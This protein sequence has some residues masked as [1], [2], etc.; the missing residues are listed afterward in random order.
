METKKCIWMEAGA[1]EYQL[2]PLKLNCDLCEF[3]QEM[4]SGSKT[5]AQLSD[6]SRFP[7]RIPDTS[8]L[9]FTA[10]VQF[11]QGHFWYKRVARGR[12]QLGIDSFLWQL[13]SSLKKVITPKL[14][15]QILAKQCFGWLL[16]EGG[17]VYLKSPIQGSILR[18]NPLFLQESIHDPHLYLVPQADLWLVEMEVDELEEHERLT[19]DGYLSM[20]ASSKAQ[21]DAL[22]EGDHSSSPTPRNSRLDKNGFSIFIKSI[23]ADHIY[24]C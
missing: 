15:A 3:H 11:L 23:S 12:I 22:I 17:I 16:I 6:A 20:V 13:F 14:N 19:K 7:I 4:I 1:V 2:C 10:G 18:I 5:Q 8:I 21:F 9:E 24:I